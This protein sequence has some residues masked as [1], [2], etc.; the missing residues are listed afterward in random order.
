MLTTLL[1]SI[2]Q[3]LQNEYNPNLLQTK[4]DSNLD[5]QGQLY[6]KLIERSTDQIQIEEQVYKYFKVWL[7]SPVFL[8][9]HIS[10]EIRITFLQVL[11][12]I[13]DVPDSMTF[14]K[15]SEVPLH[16]I[17]DTIFKISK[18]QKDNQGLVE[19][20][21]VLLI[22]QKMLRRDS[23]YTCS[24]LATEAT[25]RQLLQIG[26]TKKNLS[27]HI[28]YIM[29]LISTNSQYASNVHVV[30]EQRGRNKHELDK[31]KSSERAE[32]FNQ[33]W[34]PKPSSSGHAKTYYEFNDV[35]KINSQNQ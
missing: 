7:Q 6:A 26:N 1:L 28:E 22:T 15:T 30:L 31:Y 11:Y 3:L 33:M 19:D 8:D 23:E 35:D 9:N 2:E 14:F 10:D 18:D 34:R 20:S 32:I 12:L 29:F 24:Q 16:F 21:L 4:K 17:T 25:L 5:A 13:I 27:K